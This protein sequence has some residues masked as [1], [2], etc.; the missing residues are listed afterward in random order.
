MALASWFPGVVP[1]MTKAVGVLGY[2]SS[3]QKHYQIFSRLAD[4]F[5][6]RENGNDPENLDLLIG[7]PPPRLPHQDFLQD[8][9]FWGGVE[10]LWGGGG[11]A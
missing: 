7:D 2:V 1:D 10:G 11:V 6:L 8:F 9:T 3:P 4:I 5:D